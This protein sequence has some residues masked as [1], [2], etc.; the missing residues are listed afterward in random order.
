LNA[1]LNLVKDDGKG[2]NR[3]V[4]CLSHKRKE[5]TAHAERLSLPCVLFRS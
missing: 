2:G 1:E 4:E 3:A 5:L